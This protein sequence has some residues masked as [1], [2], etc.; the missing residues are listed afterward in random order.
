M[1][2]LYAVVQDMVV[3][4]RG[5]EGHDPEAFA[6]KILDEL[7]ADQRLA[8]WHFLPH[9]SHLFS[10]ESYA[11]GYYGYL[12]AEVLDADVFQ[13]AQRAGAGLG[14]AIAQRVTKRMGVDWRS[15]QRNRPE[16]GPSSSCCLP[17][18]TSTM[19]EYQHTRHPCHYCIAI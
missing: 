11:A 18:R 13:W 19:D 5:L 6:H 1:R 10:S 8:A 4:T 3:H 16:D 2:Y 17:R 14:L 12:W 9:F 15:W 7:G